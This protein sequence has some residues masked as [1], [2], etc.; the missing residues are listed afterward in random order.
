MSWDDAYEEN[1]AEIAYEKFMKAINISFNERFPIGGLQKVSK[2]LKK[3][4]F[5]T[6][7][8]NQL[9]NKNK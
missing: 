1:N 6:E 7:L 4:W 3:P 2:D 5:T 8:K 9:R